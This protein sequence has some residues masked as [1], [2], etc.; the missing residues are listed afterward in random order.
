MANKRLRLKDDELEIIQEFRRIK[1]ESIK[2][3]IPI[4]DVKHGW[5]KSDRSSL[6]FKNPKFKDQTTQQFQKLKESL[7]SQFKDYAPNYPTQK[8]TKSKDGHLLVISPTDIHIG[9]LCSSFETGEDYNQQ[10]AVKRVKDGVNGILQESS[11]WDIEKIL[12]II[13]NDILHTDT[14]SK[15]TKGTLQ[16][17]DGNWY[18]NFLTGVRLYVD[19]VNQLK[20]VAPVHVLH[21]PSNHD[22]QSGFFLAQLIEAHFNQCKDVTFDCSI[23]H[24]KY[25]SW[26]DNLFGA[27][28]GDGAKTA[29]LPML[30]AHESK[31]WTKCKHRYIFTG[32]LHHRIQRDHFS[33]CIIT[34]RSP[35]STDSWHHIKGYQHAP[36][37]IEAF[38]FHKKQGQ[39]ASLVHLF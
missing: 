32:H 14:P 15:T 6:F 2:Q 16:E 20:A 25:F 4:E 19:L 38:I 21:A 36:K 7:I 39:K 11:G 37:A 31:D 1:D 29:D 34:T 12:L 3:G 24:R 10:I 23:A 13:G 27:T 18:D 30:M 28:H 8:R 5:I 17:T 33:V 26:H 9:K 22:Y 35:S